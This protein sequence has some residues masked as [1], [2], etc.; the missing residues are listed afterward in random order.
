[1]SHL[2]GRIRKFNG[3]HYQAFKSFKRKTEAQSM[4]SSLRFHGVHATLTKE[5][6]PLGGH[7]WY[8]WIR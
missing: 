2:L 4:A 1:M 8:V 6:D 7:E 5:S 3:K